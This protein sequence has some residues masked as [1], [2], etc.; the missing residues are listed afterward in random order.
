M[1]KH[2]A[3]GR[4][5][6]EDTLAEAGW[7]GPDAAPVEAV[8]VEAERVEAEPAPLVVS[9]QEAPAQPSAPVFR[10]PRSRSRGSRAVAGVMLVF[11]AVVGA[12]AFAAFNAVRDT[13]E[14]GLP[15]IRLPEP[16][17]IRVTPPD[18]PGETG[19]PATGLAAGSLLQP[20]R[21]EAALAELRRAGGRPLLLRLAPDRIDTQLRDAE[22]TRIVQIGPDG[23]LRLIATAPVGG[24]GGDG[25]DLAAVDP[26]IP[27]RM[28]LAAE[29]RYGLSP[30]SI[31]YLAVLSLSG[32]LSWNAYYR[33]GSAR[34]QAGPDG[35]ITRRV[36]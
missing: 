4:E 27:R 7:R 18:Q 20:Q 11:L 23:D 36:S 9:S 21:L 13:I 34:V 19:A 17:A 26:R 8:P 32:E 30:D 10:A 24:G 12:G 28:L 29:R 14:D 5:I 33:N 6:G 31:D 22:S 25:V 15:D 2:D 16:E 35:R 3:F 1:A